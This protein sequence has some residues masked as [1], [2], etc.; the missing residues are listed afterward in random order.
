MSD[1]T[2][3]LKK[4]EIRAEEI[5]KARVEGRLPDYAKGTPQEK[6]RELIAK[7]EARENAVDKTI[8]QKIKRQNA[9]IKAK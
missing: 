7:A 5:Q 9:R 1:F 8:G 3:A 6:K 4:K 2:D